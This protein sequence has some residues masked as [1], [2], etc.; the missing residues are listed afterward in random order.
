M[1]SVE[2]ATERRTARD[3]EQSE[4]WL[5]SSWSSAQSVFHALRFGDETPPT[6][7]EHEKRKKA[8]KSGKEPPINW[9]EVEAQRQAML[10]S[11]ER[12]LYALTGPSYFASWL[13]VEGVLEE[14]EETF[15]EWQQKYGSEAKPDY[16][17]MSEALDASTDRMRERVLREKREREH[18]SGKG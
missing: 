8:E 4:R 13:G 11:K 1:R 6:K 16:K 18:L 10:D 5:L 7:E 9:K 15:E 17:S 2:R 14:P 12:L 3:K